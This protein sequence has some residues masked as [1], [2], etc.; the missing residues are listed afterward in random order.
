MTRRFP[1]FFALALGASLAPA[2][3]RAPTGPALDDVAALL[4]ISNPAVSNSR[5]FDST[6][7]ALFRE[8]VARVE[9]IQGRPGVDALL[10]DWRRLQE[11]LK[12]EAVSASRPAI[13]AKL[14]AIHNE[15]LRVVERV[16]GARAVTR[17]ISEANIGLAEARALIAVAASGEDMSAANSVADRVAARLATARQAISVSAAREALD[18][19]SQAASLLAGLRYYLIESRRV[20]GLETLLPQAIAKLSAE[21]RDA[22]AGELL[23]RIESLNDRTRA[24]LRAGDRAASHQLLADARAEQIRIVLRVLGNASAQQ[25]VEKVDE[26]AGEAAAGVAAAKAAGR[27]VAKLERMLHEAQ[28]MNARAQTALAKGDAETALDLGSHAAGLLNAVQHQ[29]WN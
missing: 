5:I 17:V 14:A 20:G 12:A 21:P 29:T 13:Q 22:S 11:E 3:D 26:R 9:K 1:W 25:L 2:C 16:L 8:S 10:G 6:L 28:D 24:T 19:A 23:A 7:P 4:S 27:D 18:E 15:E